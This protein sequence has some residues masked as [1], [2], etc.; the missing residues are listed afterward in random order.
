MHDI[1]EDI[2]YP[3]DHAMEERDQRAA[4]TEMEQTQWW[5]R[6]E[7]E[8]GDEKTWMARTARIP[9]EPPGVGAR[10]EPRTS[11]TGRPEE[12]GAEQNGPSSQR[13]MEGRLLQEV[14][15]HGRQSGKAGGG[16]PILR[17]EGKKGEGSVPGTRWDG[18]DSHDRR[19]DVTGSVS[20][21]L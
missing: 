13:S 20:R 17:S 2:E 7:R 6:N 10:S 14:A 4:P 21:E 8:E 18:P 12:S 1:A 11:P 5:V 9:L 19:L 15:S 16:M 3:T